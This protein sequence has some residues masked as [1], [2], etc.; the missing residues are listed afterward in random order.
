MGQENIQ[1]CTDWKNLETQ[2]DKK[3]P[4][5]PQNNLPLSYT[6]GPPCILAELNMITRVR[7]TFG[8]LLR[9]AENSH[10]GHNHRL[11]LL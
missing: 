8:F 6:N 9:D 7:C 2:V 3:N 5:P 11:L 10:D 1:K 4:K